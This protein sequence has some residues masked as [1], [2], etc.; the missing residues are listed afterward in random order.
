M[1]KNRSMKGVPHLRLATVCEVEKAN[2]V[3]FG[4]LA[5]ILRNFWSRNNFIQFWN[6]TELAVYELEVT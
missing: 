5:K 1:L 2:R 3:S 4:I 6:F